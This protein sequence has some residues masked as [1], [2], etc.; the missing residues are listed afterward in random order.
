MKHVEAADP[1]AMADR[2]S[3]DAELHQLPARDDPVLPVREGGDLLVGGS[4]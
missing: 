3:I 2:V 1:N 4:R